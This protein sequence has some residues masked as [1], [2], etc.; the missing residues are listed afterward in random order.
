V[1]RPQVIED[2]RNTRRVHDR[3]AAIDLAKESGYVVLAPV[4]RH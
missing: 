3:V 1:S 4:T 2:R